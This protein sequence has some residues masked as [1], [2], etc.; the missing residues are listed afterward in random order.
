LRQVGAVSDFALVA[1]L[2]S[3]PHLESLED[4]LVRAI[5]AEDGM[6]PL[7]REGR[8]AALWRVLDYGNLVIHLMHESTRNFYGIERLWEGS[9]AVPW[10]VKGRCV[11]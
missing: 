3:H 7:R 11:A 10:R 4:S 9:R 5:H 6:R 2:E 1:T 8:G